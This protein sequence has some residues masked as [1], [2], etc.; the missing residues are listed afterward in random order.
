MIQIARP[1]DGPAS[2][3]RL[4]EQQTRRDCAAYDQCP[5]DYL[6]GAAKFPNRKYYRAAKELLVEMHHLKCCYCEKR[7][8]SPNLHVEHFRPKAGVRQTLD[9][10]KDE[11]PGYYWLAYSW[12]NLL[13]SCHD[14]NNLYKGTRFPLANPKKRARSH[15]DDLA[16]E[17]PLFVDPVGQDPRDHIRFDGDLP[18]GITQQ[19]RITID[20]IGLR[21]EQLKEDRL[22]LLGH[23]A[24]GLEIIRLAA[25]HSS[26]AEL[27]ALA[28]EVR[29]FINTRIRPQAEFSSMVRDYVAG[30]AL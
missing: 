14:C 18:I 25:A 10:N 13:L 28:S 4:G 16:K 17:K 3:K 7:F 19:G 9:Q 27:E 24:R 29:E 8:S 15:H 1:Y 12:G 23:I 20:G 26:I 5:G 21:R 22:E 30:L 11:L 2:L 6:F